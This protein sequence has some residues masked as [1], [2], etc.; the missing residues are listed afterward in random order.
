MV[1]EAAGAT[2]PEFLGLVLFVSWFALRAQ[3]DKAEK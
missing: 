3:N 2:L 1:W